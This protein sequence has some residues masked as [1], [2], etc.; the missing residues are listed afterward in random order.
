MECET[1]E[2]HV[3]ELK[4]EGLKIQQPSGSSAHMEV[5]AEGASRI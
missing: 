4:L 3:E 5:A 1:M 2:F